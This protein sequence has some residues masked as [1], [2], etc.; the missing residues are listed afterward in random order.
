MNRQNYHFLAHL[1]LLQ[2]SL[3]VKL[4]V[5]T[6]RSR[7]LTRLHSLSSGDS[8]TGHRPQ[9][10]DEVS[11]HHN[12]QSTD[13][14]ALHVLRNT[15][16]LIIQR[17]AVQFCRFYHLAKGNEWFEKRCKIN[18]ATVVSYA[19]Y[20]VTRL[21]PRSRRKQ[22]IHSTLSILSHSALLIGFHQSFTRE[23]TYYA[24]RTQWNSEVFRS[25]LIVATY[26]NQLK[27]SSTLDAMVDVFGNPGMQITCLGKITH[28]R[29]AH[30]ALYNSPPPVLILSNILPLT[31]LS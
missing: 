31:L 18:L 27:H 26:N 7:S 20:H 24:S 13:A 25:T 16:E 30:I 10:W 11:R 28:F 19:L 6:S 17:R 22:P 14:R 2:R 8:T 3:V 15:C 5:R 1:L 4:G 12:Y 9:C 29:S 21:E 23:E